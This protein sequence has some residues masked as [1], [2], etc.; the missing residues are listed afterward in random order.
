MVEAQG[1]STT[2]R[3][4]EVDMAE[5]MVKVTRH[6]TLTYELKR[7]E[8]GDYTDEEI[9]EE[10]SAPLDPAALEQLYR[11]EQGK[12]EVELILTF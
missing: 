12:E 3:Q 4:L 1:L 8:Y 2:V 7:S 9:I 11:S 5:P 6:I 10:E